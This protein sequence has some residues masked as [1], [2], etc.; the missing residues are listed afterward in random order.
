MVWRRRIGK[1]KRIQKNVGNKEPANKQNGYQNRLIK[2][3][4]KLNN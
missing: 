2:L 1:C 3:K 4:I